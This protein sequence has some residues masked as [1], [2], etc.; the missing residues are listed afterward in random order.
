M[1]GE[2]G[3]RGAAGRQHR[4]GRRLDA[5]C[6]RAGGGV[7]PGPHDGCAP[8]G[9][10]G[11]QHHAGSGLHGACRPAGGLRGRPAVRPVPRF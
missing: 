5:R 2:Q 6:L 3:G 10:A 1:R 9:C 11:Q 7:E 4:T 8:R